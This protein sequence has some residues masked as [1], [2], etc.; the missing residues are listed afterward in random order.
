MSVSDVTLQGPGS[1]TGSG[2]YFDQ[3]AGTAVAGLEIR[4]VN[5]V[6]FCGDNVYLNT[7]ITSTFTN[8]RC[9]ISPSC[10]S[11]GYAFHTLSGT[12]LAFHACYADGQFLTGYYLDSLHYS[13]L[14]G[15]A[16]DST[17]RAYYLTS[18][19]CVTLTGCGC[20]S[21][22]IG[23]APY[24]GYGFVVNGGLSNSLDGCRVYKNPSVAFW[25]TGSAKHTTLTSCDENAPAA[26][27]TASYKVDSGSTAVA[28]NLGWS[29]QP[30]F[31]TGTT[32]LI[33][34]TGPTTY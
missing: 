14:A 28:T 27:A 8:V 23:T 15:C 24:S 16:A 11:T 17:S 30:S 18:C 19:Q 7:P 10:T 9:Q 31:A 26:G 5:I 13:S 12:S 21:N 4:D 3:S 6:N 34:S 1:G 29:T 2:I 22:T 20:E 32:Y 25:A 33:Q